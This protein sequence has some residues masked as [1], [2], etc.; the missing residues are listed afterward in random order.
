MPIHVRT[1]VF[2]GPFDLLLQL[3]T[4]H[5]VEVTDIGLTDV[6]TEYLAFIDEMERLDI[7]V[8]SEF[9]L[10]AATLVQLKMQSLLPRPGDL[11]LDEELD[12]DRLA[13]VAAMSRWHWHRVYAGMRGETVA[14][15][16][17]RLRL[18][19]RGACGL[20]LLDA[21]MRQ[22]RRDRRDVC[23][24]GGRPRELLVIS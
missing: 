16:V 21:G 20:L 12:L 19:V 18:R 14:A 9:L 13:D 6:V 17:R 4:R 10:I 24:G 1:T 11:D 5:Q 7:E 15:T 2:E 23:G 22:R 8:T 3:I